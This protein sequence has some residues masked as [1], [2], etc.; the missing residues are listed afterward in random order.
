MDEESGSKVK[1]K[2]FTIMRFEN[3]RF[4]IEVML[5]KN[6]PKGFLNFFFLKNTT[7]TQSWS[8]VSCSLILTSKSPFFKICLG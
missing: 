7:H 1:Q 8:H 4:D 5:E 6:G 2:S 3:L